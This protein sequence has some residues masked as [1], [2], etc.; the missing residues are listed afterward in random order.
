M[1]KFP[2][3]GK[4]PKLTNPNSKLIGQKLEYALKRLSYYL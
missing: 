3:I 2:K 1:F 4:E